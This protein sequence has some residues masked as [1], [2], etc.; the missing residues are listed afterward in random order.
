M[1]VV[2][3]GAEPAGLFLAYRLLALSPSYTVQIYEC[4]VGD[5]LQSHH[6]AMGGCSE[7]AKYL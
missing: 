4:K 5:S 6:F 2:I 7:T 1:H 3:V